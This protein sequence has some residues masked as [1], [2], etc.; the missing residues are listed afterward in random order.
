MGLALNAMAPIALAANRYAGL[1]TAPVRG[2]IIAAN[3]RLLDRL[4]PYCEVSIDDSSSLPRWSGAVKGRGACHN[5]NVTKPARVDPGHFGGVFHLPPGPNRAF[6][7]WQLTGK[8]YSDDEVFYPIVNYSIAQTEAMRGTS[9]E[10]AEIVLEP[11][12]LR[13]CRSARRSRSRCR[14]TQSTSPWMCS[15]QTAEVQFGGRH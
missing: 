7:Y 13:L 11:S 9:W 5:F 8:A 2:H 12:S 3:K 1:P 14:T 10:V 15:W 4:K 6:L